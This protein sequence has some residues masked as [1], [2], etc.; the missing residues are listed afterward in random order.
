MLVTVVRRF[1]GAE[2]VH[3][4]LLGATTELLLLHELTEFHIDGFRVLPRRDVEV[5]SHAKAQRYR[6]AILRAERQTPDASI[7]SA[8]DLT[9]WDALLRSL[10]ARARNVIVEN[11]R[12]ESEWFVIGEVLRVN[13]RSA[14][15]RGFDALGRWDPEP[16]R[17]K[18]EEITSV[19]FENEYV[20]V[21]S[22][23]LRDG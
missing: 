21:F 3:G 19:Q 16:T 5:A 17:V 4:F 2:N 11:E 23:Y 7:L 14:A 6:A 1:E 12:L 9:G 10:K 8:V 15:V 22:K 13:K 18:Y 20:N